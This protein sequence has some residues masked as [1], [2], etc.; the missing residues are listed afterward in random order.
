M[1]VLAGALGVAG[2][3]DFE[4]PVQSKATVATASSVPMIFVM[5]FVFFI[6]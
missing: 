3:S 2:C 4:Q 1:F 5:R 6:V